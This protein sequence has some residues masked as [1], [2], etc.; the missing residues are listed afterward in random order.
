MNAEPIF[1]K[2]HCHLCGGS[3][4][5]PIEGADTWVTCPHCGRETALVIPTSAPVRPTGFWRRTFEKIKKGYEDVPLP[6]EPVEP[7]IIP[8]LKPCGDCGREISIRAV[9]CP[10]CGAPGTAAPAS[11]PIRQATIKSKSESFGAG[12]FLQLIG[13]ILLFF[14]PVGT[15][16][17]LA[18]I[19]WGASAARKPICSNCGNLIGSRWAKVC[20]ACEA[21]FQ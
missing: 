14:F 6:P 3:I 13:I 11:I 8:T 15:V 17:G 21:H 4:E 1:A 9:A 12:C 5:F 10:H 16:I 7:P 20:P 19:V 2:C 18:L